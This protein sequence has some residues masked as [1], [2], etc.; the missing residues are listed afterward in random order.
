MKTEFRRAMDKIPPSL[1]RYT[2]Y[3][4]NFPLF[5]WFEASLEPL[6]VITSLS[7][8]RAWC[9]GVSLRH[10]INKP[11]EFCNTDPTSHY[12]VSIYMT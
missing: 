9:L 3:S 11:H 6:L 7:L 8:H 2:T 12:P 4:R 1:R 5:S 10:S